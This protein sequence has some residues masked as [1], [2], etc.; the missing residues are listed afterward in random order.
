MAIRAP[1]LGAAL[2]PRGAGGAAERVLAVTGG[3]LLAGHG[4]HPGPAASHPGRWCWFSRGHRWLCRREDGQLCPV[5]APSAGGGNGGSACPQGLSPPGVP[6]VG[7][8]AAAA[9]DQDARE[10]DQGAADEDGEQGEEQH[11]AILGGHLAGHRLRRAAAAQPGWGTQPSPK[12]SPCLAVGP[13]LTPSCSLETFGLPRHP[14]ACCRLRGPA[15]TTATAAE[16]AEPPAAPAPH[17]D[18]DRD[19][20]PAPAHPPTVGEGPIQRQQPGPLGPPAPAAPLGAAA[21]TGRCHTHTLHPRTGRAGWV[22]A[23]LG[24]C[25]PHLAVDPTAPTHTPQALP[26][27]HPR[28]PPHPEEGRAGQGSPRSP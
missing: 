22:A 17:G 4:T 25:C 12:P 15:F 6:A 24:G 10:Q 20:N 21:G 27:M 7:L 19:P 23:G 14:R 18:G 8:A 3:R 16:G 2:P 5:P 28:A 26:R 1:G 13:G 9:D 11:V